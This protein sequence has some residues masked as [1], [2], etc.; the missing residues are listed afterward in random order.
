MLI[1]LYRKKGRYFSVRSM[2]WE[3]R[4][5]RDMTIPLDLVTIILAFLLI[6]PAF[7]ALVIL[8]KKHHNSR[9]QSHG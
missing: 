3:K 9:R 8:Y 6:Y 5:V 7:L 4:E 2:T 1:V